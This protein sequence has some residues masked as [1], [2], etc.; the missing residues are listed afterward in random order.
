LL[1]FS[2]GPYFFGLREQRWVAAAAALDGLDE[3][4]FASGFLRKL[5]PSVRGMARVDADV[6]SGGE[7]QL[8]LVLV[9]KRLAI[10]QEEDGKRFYLLDQAIQEL[11]LESLATRGLPLRAS[12]RA[13]AQSST[14]TN[15]TGSEICCDV[16]QALVPAAPRLVSALEPAN[17]VNR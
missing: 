10:L 13:G 12:A 17:R 9:S 16:A 4:V 6:P 1:A 11:L 8:C 5:T 15:D 2:A 14:L 3:Q 7:Q